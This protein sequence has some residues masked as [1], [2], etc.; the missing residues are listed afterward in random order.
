[1]AI[2]SVS[3][4]ELSDTFDVFRQNVNLIRQRAAD[5]DANNEFSGT[6]TFDSANVTTLNF[7]D[8]TT[9]TTAPTA[10]DAIPFAIALG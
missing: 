9:L 3:N 1:M 4:T 10:A 2:S 7:A 6:Q 5:A 8:N